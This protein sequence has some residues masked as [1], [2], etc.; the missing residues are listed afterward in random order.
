MQKKTII[1][2]LV[3]LGML[4]FVISYVDT[5]KLKNT[6]AQIPLSVIVTVTILYALGQLLSTLKWW[7]I[8][9]NSVEGSF[10][11]ALRAYWI[12]MYVNA[13]GLGTLGGDVTRGLLYAQGKK[14]K[15]ESL[16]SVI[17]DRAHGLLVLALIGIISVLLVDQDKIDP[18]FKIFLVLSF[19]GII[20]GWFLGPALLLKFTPKDSKWRN[21][22][23]RTAAQFPRTP[24]RLIAIT[25][26]SALFHTTQ[27]LTHV[28]MAVAIGLEI[29]WSRFFTA[30]PF[31]NILGTL[32]ISWQGLGV[33][34]TSLL[35]FLKNYITSEQALTLGAIWFIAVTASSC[36]G[37]VVAAATGDLKSIEKAAPAAQ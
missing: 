27:I 34:E 25:A 29:H 26:L 31:V 2:I 17:A 4:A 9:S 5:E 8:V 7:L 12:G 10:G 1:K 6:I 3:S 24:S 19:V 23:E 18:S 33:R 30:I 14:A 37:G 28:Y 16:A 20:I 11:K 13:F 36:I 32:P 35:F 15:T 22:V 21:K